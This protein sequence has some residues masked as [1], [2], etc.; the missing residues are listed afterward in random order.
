MENREIIDLLKEGMFLPEVNNVTEDEYISDIEKA[1]EKYDKYKEDEIILRYRVVRAD[2]KGNLYLDLGLEG[3]T[4]IILN[5]EV[6]GEEYNARKRSIYVNTLMPVIITDINK[7]T[8]EVYF[9]RY[10][11]REKAKQILRKELLRALE[12]NESITVKAKVTKIGIGNRVYIDI[13]GVGILGY[14][15]IKQWDHKFVHNVKEEIPLNS[16]ISVVPI[17]YMPE[18]RAK[19]TVFGEVFI[20]SRKEALPD[21][22]K[23]IEKKLPVNTVLVVKCVQL[24]DKKWWGNTP[25]LNL[26]IYCEYPEKEKLKRDIQIKLGHKYKVFIYRVNEETRLLKARV[27]DEIQED[28]E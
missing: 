6:N 20:C 9:S 19:G 12:N 27:I 1:L 26:D 28:D 14:V 11:A 22:W 21:P 18:Q 23:D 25:G 7:E 24:E 3:L 10:Q 16:Q 4:G 8:G 13:G 2:N 17:K 5:K 15:P